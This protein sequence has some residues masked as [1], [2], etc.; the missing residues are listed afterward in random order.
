MPRTPRM[1]RKGVAWRAP[2]EVS[3]NQRED[4]TYA[5]K[6]ECTLEQVMHDLDLPLPNEADATQMRRKLGFI[7]GQWQTPDKSTEA[8]KIKT[9]TVAAKLKAIVA[10]PKMGSAVYA[11]SAGSGAHGRAD[12]EAACSLAGAVARH[13][14]T[15]DIGEGHRLLAEHKE[16]APN[17]ASAAQEALDEVNSIRGKHGRPPCAWHDDFLRFLIAVAEKNGVTPTLGW[18]EVKYRPVGS[19]A[20]FACVFERLLPPD[21]RSISP[22]AMK[23]RLY[24]SKD[25]IG[26][27]SGR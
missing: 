16:N 7:I 12:I 1:P 26:W 18:D 15:T 17:L 10:D 9:G 5:V 21:M 13:A 2:S 14:G 19:I 27:A 20:H 6:I 4:G 11:V 3:Y 23:E 22:V 8:D 24:T 25:R